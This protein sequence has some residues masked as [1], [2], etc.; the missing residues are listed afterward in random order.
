VTEL[1]ALLTWRAG[2]DAETRD[3]LGAALIGQGAFVRRVLAGG[4]NAG[5]LL[6]RMRG[7][8]QEIADDFGLGALYEAAVAGA[9]GA[10]YEAIAGAG[11]P[12]VSPIYRTALFGA[13]R[14]P[15][16]AR[17]AAFE[18]ETAAMPRRVAGIAGWCLGTVRRAWGRTAW[19]HVWEQGYRQLEDLTQDYMHAP[20]HWGQVDRWFDPEHPDWLID[21]ALCHAFS[22]GLEE[23][24]AS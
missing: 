11:D 18:A 23:P 24:L 19:T 1:V 20:C 15:S 17:L 6:V 14:D 7:P 13:V 21:P 3:R 2:A 10:I 5:D 4:R 9:D 8:V 16:P 12:L 22:P